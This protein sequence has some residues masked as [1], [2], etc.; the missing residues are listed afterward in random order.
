MTT[1][2]PLAPTT[3]PHHERGD[4][5]SRARFLGISEFG[6]GNVI[7]HNG[8]IYRCDQLKISAGIGLQGGPIKS[9]NDAG[10]TTRSI[11]VCPKCGHYMDIE[12]GLPPNNCANCGSELSLSDHYDELYR[13]SVVETC[14][15]ERITVADEER[16][17]QGF[18]LRTFYHFDEQSS[19]THKRKVNV[20]VQDNQ[21]MELSYGDSAKLMRVNT[22]WRKRAQKEALGFDIAESTGRWLDKLQEG[23]EDPKEQKRRRILPYVYDQ[24]NVLII[25][26]IPFMRQAWQLDDDTYGYRS[27]DQ[28]ELMQTRERMRKFMA[29]VKAALSRAIAQRFQ[30]ELSE[31]FV[32]A[33]PDSNNPTQ[34][35]IY[36]SGEGGS[37]VL[38]R[39]CLAHQD[40][41][42]HTALA[43]VAETALA[44][45]HYEKQEDAQ[46][47]PGREAQ[48][49]C[50]SKKECVA[51]YD[52]LFTY[53]NQPD[54]A[55]IDRRMLEVYDFFVGLTHCRL[56]TVSSTSENSGILEPQSPEE[57]LA[58]WFNAQGYVEPTQMPWHS[59]TFAHDFAAY[60]SPARVVVVFEA[61]SDELKMKLDEMAISYVELNP[62]DETSWEQA[63]APYHDLL[64]K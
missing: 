57:R 9:G 50:D 28:S 8:G 23:K 5:L 20:L 21:T 2:A 6:P 17:R 59:E 24:R 4:W 15:V 29:T 51:C 16:R 38:K 53:Y 46:W 40:A 18:D 31:I 30:I 11:A 34:L 7:Y 35:L 27:Y 44:I 49:A 22:G 39:L 41:A 1:A 14:K 10:L 60:F 52:C 47:R 25:D 19:G 33:L 13:V 56:E 3:S 37:G 45:M 48:H 54:H 42:G 63:F 12:R 58:Q 64:Q 36:E 43:A 61:L 26:F 32:E 62:N 55:L